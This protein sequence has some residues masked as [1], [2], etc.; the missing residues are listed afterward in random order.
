MSK[1]QF[2]NGFLWGGAIA[3]NQA[4]G[5]WNIDGKGPSIMDIEILPEKYSL[6]SILGYS[7][8]DDSIEFALKDDDSLYPRR[9]GID[10]Y[11]TYESDLE[12]MKEMGFTTFRTSINWPRIFPKGIEQEPNKKGLEFYDRLIGKIVDLG[13]EPIITISHYEMPVY[14][15]KEYNGFASREVIDFYLN[16]ATTIVDRYHDKVKYWIP[17]NQ[18]NCLDGWGEYGS[19]GLKRGYDIQT[20]YQA[21]HHQFVAAAKLTKYIHEKCPESKVS[22]MLGDNTSYPATSKPED[23][24]ATTQRNQMQQYFFSDVMIR[25]SYPGYAKRYFSEKGISLCITQEDAEL[26]KQN[27]VDF[28]TFSYYFTGTIAYENGDIVSKSNPYL[29]KNKWGWAI[30]PLGLR[31]ALNHYWDRYE[32]SIFISENGFGHEDIIEDGRIHDTYRINYLRE[33]IKSIRDAIGD[34]VDVFGYT[35]WGPIDIVSASQGE[36]S[37]RYGYIYVDLDDHGLGTAKRVRK[38]SFY[39]YKDVIKSNGKDL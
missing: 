18:V 27:P 11:H 26:L 2:P 6:T 39:W 37:K 36:M 38:D 21:V 19:L 15:V 13:M 32:K 20:V 17:F 5:A 8:D 3:A 12:L 7:H 30:D 9:R 35:S 33:H 34:G 23:V 28:L 1:S 14:L 25:G 22:V 16:F 4:E 31:N 29:E 24:F 10:F